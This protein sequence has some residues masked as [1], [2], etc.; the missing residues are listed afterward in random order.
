MAKAV[1]Q[2]AVKIAETTYDVTARVTL[3]VGVTVTANGLA[4]AVDAAESLG[5]EDLGI[6]VHDLQDYGPVTIRSIYVRD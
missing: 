4:G 5:F 3:D 6:N 2:K 1:A